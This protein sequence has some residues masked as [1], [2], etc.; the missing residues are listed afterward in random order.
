MDPKDILLLVFVSVLITA[1]ISGAICFWIIVA[2]RR[3]NR[4]ELYKQQQ[5]LG[6][7]LEAQEAE[8]N[9]LG[10]DLH[11]ELGPMLT[12]L[13][14]K[15]THLALPENTHHR[16]D[17]RSFHDMIDHT[18]EKIRQV[19]RNLVSPV[20]LEDGLLIMLRQAVLQLSKNTAFSIHI[21]SN[22]DYIEL[23]KTRSLHVFRSIM[24]LIA[25]AMRH[26]EA[27]QI[28]VDIRQ[29]AGQYIFTINDNGKG[30]PDAV[31]NAAGIGLTN[32]NA[33]ASYIGGH[34]FI[35]NQPGGGTKAVLEVPIQQKSIQHE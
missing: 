15:T 19:A 23:D 29:Q 33:R 25:N 32:V 17:I 8:R 1:L 27:S 30:M 28:L 31:Q 18:I 11:D 26:G 13:R 16:A 6:V 10:E 22:T 21:Q 20:L 7:V 34:F 12:A 14:W 4:R 35:Q 24:E 3:I 5:L 9:R 2:Q